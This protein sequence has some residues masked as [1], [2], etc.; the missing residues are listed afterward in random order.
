[1]VPLDPP[2]IVSLYHCFLEIVQG[3]HVHSC[4]SPQWPFCLLSRWKAGAPTRGSLCFYP[5]APEDLLWF[6]LLSQPPALLEICVCSLWGVW[7]HNAKCRLL[8]THSLSLHICSVLS[9]NLRC[10]RHWFSLLLVKY[11]LIASFLSQCVSF[12]VPKLLPFQSSNITPL[13]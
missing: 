9:W 8:H 13:N 3:T 10:C 7:T 4:A 11:V 6:C 5:V 12:L 1:M 2:G